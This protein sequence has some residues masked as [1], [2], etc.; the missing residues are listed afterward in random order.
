[1]TSLFDI[2]SFLNILSDYFTKV[3]FIK[4]HHQVLFKIVFMFLIWFKYRNENKIKQ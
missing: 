1:M 2:I 3:S 4:L